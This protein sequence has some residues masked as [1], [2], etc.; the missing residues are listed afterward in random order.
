[1]S[2]ELQK[3]KTKVDVLEGMFGKDWFAAMRPY[4]MSKEFD[5]MAKW[6]N[7]ERQIKKVFPSQADVFRAFKLTP[8]HQVKVVLLGTDPY[9]NEGQAL[10]VS[11]GIDMNKVEGGKFPTALFNLRNELE[12]DL[13]TLAINFDY[14]LEGWAEQGVLLLNTA[15]TVQRGNLGSHMYEWDPFTKHVIEAINRKGRFS[16][17]VVWILLG[18][19]AQS[20]K[21]YIDPNG[22]RIVETSHPSPLSV[23]RGFD[24]SGIFSKVNAALYMT[25]QD[26]IE[27]NI[28]DKET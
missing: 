12:R 25:E 10:G 18:K 14:T 28:V 15:L 19:Q 5:D 1:M 3:P 4:L 23:H 21:R 27:W 2:T 8:F 6:L 24:G 22:G 9:A 17:H 20:Y 26:E 7:Q 13:D 16:K 11:Y